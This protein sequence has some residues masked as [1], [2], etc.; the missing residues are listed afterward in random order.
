M[1]PP[2]PDLETRAK[3]ECAAPL[4]G[5]ALSG[6]QS[7]P[8]EG[9]G[10]RLSPIQGEI[11][12]VCAD[13]AHKLGLS[14]SVGQ[15]F[16]AIYC[17]P[18]P[19]TFAEVMAKLDLSKGS[20]SQGLHFLRELGAIKLADAQEDRRERFCPETE[21]RLLLAGL[22]QVRV[23][24][25]LE[26]GAVRLADIE[27]QLKTATEADRDFLAQRLD[28]LRVWHRKALFVLPL[29]QRALGSS[30]SG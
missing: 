10:N 14:H 17:S 20:V 24:A 11:V 25:P 8:T 1:N 9:A 21:L 4:L 13:A 30:R 19:L 27:R 29:L 18:L 26:A 23:R 6:A 15:I 22:L 12:Q 7:T 2:H 3:A 16:G 28:S 5:G